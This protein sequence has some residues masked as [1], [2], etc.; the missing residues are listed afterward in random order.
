MSD[1]TEMEAGC[2]SAIH[3]TRYLETCH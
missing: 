1:V 3:L 2:N